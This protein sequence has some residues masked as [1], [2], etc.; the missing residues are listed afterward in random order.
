MP[1]AIWR[2]AIEF[3]EAA[4]IDEKMSEPNRHMSF[5]DMCPEGLRKHLKALEHVKI[6]DYEGLKVEIS[7]GPG[8]QQDA[9]CKSSSRP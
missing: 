9:K 4:T 8:Q 5:I 2:L 1:S 6:V 7:G 3:F